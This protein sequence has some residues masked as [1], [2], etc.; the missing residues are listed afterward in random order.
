[1][2]SIKEVLSLALSQSLKNSSITQAEFSRIYPE[3]K[4]SIMISVLLDGENK[5]ESSIGLLETHGEVIMEKEETSELSEELI[6]S[7]SNQPARGLLLWTHG[8]KITEMKL[9]LMQVI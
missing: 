8:L 1:M 2:K 7:V 5:M 3:E 6:I 4:N 9:K